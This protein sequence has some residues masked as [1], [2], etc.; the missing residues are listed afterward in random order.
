[1]ATTQAHLG[2]KKKAKPE[3]IGAN[4]QV[5]APVTEPKPATLTERPAPDTIVTTAEA[6]PRS[7]CPS[8]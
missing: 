6:A 3:A 4:K 1:L 2:L 8:F 7:L 5:E